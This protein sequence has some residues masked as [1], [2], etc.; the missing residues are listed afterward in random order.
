MPVQYMQGAEPLF[1]PGS[2]TGCL[3][4]HG[5]G[6]GTAWDLREFAQLLNAKTGMKVWVPTLTGFGTRPEDLF[7][8]TF[9]DWV[10]AARNGLK[11]LGEDCDRLFVVGHSVGGLLAIVLAAEH[12]LHGMATWA[13]PLGVRDRR[14][15]LL[16]FLKRMPILRRA[17]PEQIPVPVPEELRKSGWIGYD[18]I[19]PSVAAA[20][21]V[22]MRRARSLLPRV[23]CP[24][25]I[26]QGSCD[27]MVAGASARQIYERIGSERKE[28]CIVQ[29][30][31]HPMMNQPEHKDELFERTMSFFNLL[32]QK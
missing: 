5:A 9:D 13:A 32:A 29:R 7:F 23:R 10:D 3:L 1:I 17:I 25:L 31:D 8:I 16:P 2:R 12:T 28:I 21:I 30:A 11:R 27:T 24:A 14:L 26:V 22:G 4:L 19:P 18:W 6:G 15:K 20:V